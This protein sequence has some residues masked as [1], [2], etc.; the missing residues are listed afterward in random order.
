MERA[1]SDSTAECFSLSV[2]VTR[3]QPT[4]NGYIG[5]FWRERERR[6]NKTGMRREEEKYDG[7]KGGKVAGDCARGE[8]EVI[9]I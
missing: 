5:L 9:I 6:K 8:E 4:D 1:K 7:E 2:W 3:F